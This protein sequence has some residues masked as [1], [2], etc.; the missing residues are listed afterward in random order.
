M[1]FDDRNTESFS[2]CYTVTPDKFTLGTEWY[3]EGLLDV[4]VLALNQSTSSFKKAIN[5]G[6]G[7]CNNNYLSFTIT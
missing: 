5:G 2:S 6:I 7:K 3:F 4:A 1:V